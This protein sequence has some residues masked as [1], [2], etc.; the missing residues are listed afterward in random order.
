MKGQYEGILA[1][2]SFSKTYQSVR[3][4]AEE[5]Y[6]RDSGIYGLSQTRGS[7]MSRILNVSYFISYICPL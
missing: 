6:M 5:I 1:S 2:P 7:L 4:T 3:E